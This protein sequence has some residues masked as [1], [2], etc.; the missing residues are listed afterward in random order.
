M[1]GYKLWT[2]FY[3]LSSCME[4]PHGD[5]ASDGGPFR[6]YNLGSGRTIHMYAKN[7]ALCDLAP[8]F[9]APF[10]FITEFDDVTT[11]RSR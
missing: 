6:E 1:T 2:Y 9:A 11:V 7:C 5:S 8:Y 4:I 3:D 10:S